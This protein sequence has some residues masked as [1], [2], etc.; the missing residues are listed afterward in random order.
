MKKLLAM[1]AALLVAS[2]AL[3]VQKLDIKSIVNGEFR[4]KGI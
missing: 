2:S 1:C 4:T 3:A